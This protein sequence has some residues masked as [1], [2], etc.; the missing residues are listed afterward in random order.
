[1]AGDPRVQQ[2]LEE[3]LE[4]Q[5]SPEEVCRDQPE[6]L[7]Q[8]RERWQQL[9][10]V[11]EQVGVLFPTVSPDPTPRVPAATD[12][13]RISG[14]DVQAVLGQGGMG[15]V[16]QAWHLRLNRPVALKML[17][18]GAYARPEELQRFLREAETLAGLNHPNIVRVHD[19]GGT[20]TQP[21][22]T[23]EL[24]EGG[25]LSRQ[26]AGTPQPARQAAQLLATLAEA[27]HAAHQAGIIHRDL[28]P[29]NVLL[30]ADGVPRITDFGLARRLEG[31]AGL[32]SS[33]AAVGT[34]SYMAPE[35]AQGKLRALGPAV[36]VYALGAILYELLTG[37]PPFRAETAAETLLQ[38]I[39]SEPVPPSRLNARVPRDLETICLK[40]LEKEPRRRYPSA[41]ALAE[42]LGRFLEGR[43]ILARPLSRAERCWRWSRRNPRETAL[44]G[45][46]LLVLFL[47]GGGAWW[48]DRQRA[49][50][51]TEQALQEARTRQGAQGA[52]EQARVLRRQAHW[53]EAKKAL[54]QV[55]LLIGDEGPEDLRQ[56]LAQSWRDTRMAQTLDRIAQAKATIV[57][58]RFD[59][60]QAPPAYAL[61]FRNYGLAIRDESVAELARRIRDSELEQELVDA[62]DDWIFLEP[63]D[64]VQKLVAVASA[65]DP[66]PWRDQV[67]QAMA[68][69]NMAALACLAE[70]APLAKQS[71][72]LLVALGWQLSS[73]R[74]EG[75]VIACGGA[76]QVGFLAS[77]GG[78]GPLVA[79]LARISAGSDPVRL[80]RRLQPEHLADYLVNLTLG[81]A[82]AMR[83]PG[84]AV[85]Y[86][87]AALAVRP[88]SVAVH[89]NLG[90][91]LNNKGRT[92]EAIDQ[93]RRAVQI[94]PNDLWTRDNLGMAL[95]LAGRTDEAIEQFQQILR[96]DPRFAPAH[97]HL[98]FALASQ[99]RIDESLGYFE[100]ALRIN[101]GDATV[102][103]NLGNTL[104]R[105]HRIDDAIDHFR[106][107]LRIAPRH[108]QAHNHLG[109][110][111]ANKGRI[112][113]AIDH[114]EQALRID[115]RDASAHDNLG[116]ALWLQGRIDKA[117][118][119]YRQAIAFDPRSAHAHNH[120]GVALADKGRI[121]EAIHHFQQAVQIEPANT[122]AHSN[123]G[124]SL[125]RKGQIDAAIRQFRQAVAFVPKH[126]EIQKRLRTVLML[127]GRL[128][129]ARMA[130]QAA[131][132]VD[133]PQHDA[134]YGYAEFCSYLGQEDEYRRARRDLLSRFGTTTNPQ[135]AERTGRACLLLPASGDEL[136]QAVALAERAAA[137][138]RARYQRIYPH[139]LFVQGLAEYRQGRFDR[140]I[141]T[142][143]GDASRVLG[144]APRLVLAMALH[145]S[146]EEAEARQTLAA[147]VRDHDWRANQ[148][149][150]QDGWIYHVL[151]REAER[152]I[153]PNQPR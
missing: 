24:L 67:R 56:Q 42:D 96:L 95:G 79:A 77:P 66:A 102:H 107:A 134:W 30:T 20:D 22:F 111:L 34:P 115:P 97:N 101:P 104:F 17:L 142:M 150:D 57:D 132:E 147:A 39:H 11:Q 33:G 27:M 52:L 138:D 59:T 103:V 126:T 25:S 19:A 46:A 1:M 74:E 12:L 146:G 117:I 47:V 121:D 37:R 131:L 4:S 64:L 124:Q 137:A 133:P 61:A 139:F 28:K 75:V 9:R 78:L 94:D 71:V 18:A 108:A 84:E 100:Q 145:R 112:D 38:V 87:R 6:L 152:M 73:P 88:G 21:W 143:R 60:A 50:R 41:R 35:Q 129:E 26:L 98:G 127:Q 23:M 65:V 148:V 5:R 43:P 44:A 99:G 151:R 32:T 49:L 14:Y 51:Q 118:Y 153:L 2:L 8:V 68:G 16:Y 140:A 53:A 80:L 141:A 93:F 81:T 136:R 92:D 15:V 29:A 144:P 110:A 55:A 85:S 13:P 86:Y 31:H 128:D 109:V 70:V 130:W 40:C 62:L 135:I 45:L 48:S 36:D 7:P 3:I 119:H 63:S 105:Q 120:L 122:L 91:A 106:Q 82:L 10:A 69:R 58:G 149:R 116:H 54:E 72:P 123:L 113:E 125:L 114:F 83:D 90:V 76:S 89:S